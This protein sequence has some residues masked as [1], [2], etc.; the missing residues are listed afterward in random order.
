MI[1]KAVFGTLTRFP[2]LLPS[3]ERWGVK[4]GDFKIAL[5]C[6]SGVEIAVIGTIIADN[7]VSLNGLKLPNAVVL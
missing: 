6:L 3:W 4:V 1:I 2:L 7:P 5:E